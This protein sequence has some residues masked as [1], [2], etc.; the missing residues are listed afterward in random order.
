M[1]TKAKQLVHFT[2]DDTPAEQT[3]QPRLVMRTIALL[4]AL[5]FGTLLTTQTLGARLGTRPQTV[6]EHSTAPQLQR[7]RVT[8]R[9]GHTLWGS[10]RTVVEFRKAHA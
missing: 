5:P 4:D 10:P 7:Y 3:Q 9:V 1:K 2:I 6:R 8:G